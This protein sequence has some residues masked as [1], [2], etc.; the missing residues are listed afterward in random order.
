MDHGLLP[1][2]LGK[3]FT[4]R[5]V[6]AAPPSV[7]MVGAFVAAVLACCGC[8]CCCEV[9]VAPNWKGCVGGVGVTAESGLAAP[10][11]PAP[12]PAGRLNEK[13]GAGL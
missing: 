9:P 12:G 13:V 3:P 10:K 7:N 2:R 4:L 6:V 1:R 8:C 11:A 5:G